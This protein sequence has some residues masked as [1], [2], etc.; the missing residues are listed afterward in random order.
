MM[1]NWQK[2]SGCICYNDEWGPS[3]TR[4]PDLK[5]SMG[6]VKRACYSLRWYKLSANK[7][8]VQ[9]CTTEE[10]KE[11][12]SAGSR[13]LLQ[14]KFIISWW[15]SKTEPVLR[16]KTHWVLGDGEWWEMVN[17]YHEGPSETTASMLSH[18]YSKDPSKATIIIYSNPHIMRTEG[19]KSIFRTFRC[20]I[21]V[22]RIGCGHIRT[23]S[24]ENL[25]SGLLIY[26]TSESMTRMPFTFGP[27]MSAWHGYT[28]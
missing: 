4:G 26:W 14:S 11:G 1:L 16:A 23:K 28:W 15:A 18:D 27:W 19:Y 8:S 10:D 2:Q 21:W 17:P 5:T 9:S 7:G 6:M 24:K 12:C 13:Q 25:D 3:G 20:R 22:D